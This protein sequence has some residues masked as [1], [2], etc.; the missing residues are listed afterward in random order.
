MALVPRLDLRTAQTLVMTPQL[1]QAIKLLQL[2]NIE[3]AEYV[4]QELEQNPLLEREDPDRQD[5]G[6]ENAPENVN[7]DRPEA[8]PEDQLTPSAGESNETGEEFDF[9]PSNSAGDDDIYQPDSVELVG[10]ED[11]SFTGDATLDADYENVWSGDTESNIP[12]GSDGDSLHWQVQG[13]GGFDSGD[14]DLE[15]APAG[16]IALRDHVLGQIN[17]DIADPVDRLIAMQMLD[18]LDGAGYLSADL[19]EIA[20][21][22]GCPEERVERVLA[23]VQ[24]FDPPGIFAR[25]LAECLRIQLEDRNHFDPVIQVLVENLDLLGKHE[26]KELRRLCDV[27][28]EDF[29]HMLAEIKSLNPKP[30]MAFDYSVAQPVI[31]DVNVRRSAEGGWVVELN[32]DTLPRVLINNR[33]FTEITNS[34]SREEDKEYIAECYQ[35]ANW[36]VRALHQRAQTIMKVSAEIIRQQEQFLEHGIQHLKPLVLRN[37]GEVLDI[38]ESTVS[39]VTNNKYISTPR[40]IYELKYF[41]TFAV[42]ENINGETS[43]A[44][45][46]R[47]QVKSLIDSE[48]VDNVLSDDKI[49]SI[50][51]RSGVDIARRTVAKY[52]ESMRIPSSVQRRREKTLQS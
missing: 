35:S 9:T 41:F 32:S 11:M 20:E 51:H 25:N 15:N 6:P 45:A 29:A 50:L 49:V 1:Q 27:N 16:E 37:I 21:T 30:A 43:S 28:H 8:G 22:L 5:D 14:P 48:S 52:R 44:E 39:R 2:N 40:G 10:S 7:E 12:S 38:H 23:I 24:R 26:F 46:V 3:L 31:P 33:Y 42:G 17:I 18:A 36:L 19:D 47:F 34:A 13:A 4:E